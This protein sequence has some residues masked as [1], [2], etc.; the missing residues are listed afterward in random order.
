MYCAFCAVF[1]IN[2]HESKGNWILWQRKHSWIRTAERNLKQQLTRKKN[3][4]KTNKCGH[5]MWQPT[6]ARVNSKLCELLSRWPQQR[7]DEAIKQ[8]HTWAAYYKTDYSGRGGK[9]RGRVRGRA[10]CW[11]GG[12]KKGTFGVRITL[13]V[14]EWKWFFLFLFDGNI[15]HVR[16]WKTGVVLEHTL[17][18]L[19]PYG[20][21]LFFTHFKDKATI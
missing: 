8:R 5:S 9:E 10:M 14:S 2:P 7:P 11:C 1:T 21:L 19:N 16:K 18:S 20:S 6:A 13:L 4:K 3:P 12:G 15:F 17:C